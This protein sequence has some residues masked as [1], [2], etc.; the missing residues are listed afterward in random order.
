MRHCPEPRSGDLMTERLPT[1]TA[2]RT[3]PIRRAAVAA[4]ATAMSVLLIAGVAAGLNDSLTLPAPPRASLAVVCLAAAIILARRTIRIALILLLTIAASVSLASGLSAGEVQ[5]ALGAWTEIAVLLAVVPIVSALLVRRLYIQVVI[6]AATRVGALATQL[7]VLISG[8]VIGS[9][10]LLAVVPV[11]G[12]FLGLRRQQPAVRQHYAQ[13]ILRGFVSSVAWSPSTGA[14][15]VIV[16]ATGLR[17]T[18]LAPALL[19]VGGSGLLLGMLWTVAMHRRS[20]MPVELSDEG[21]IDLSTDRASDRNRVL[22]LIGFLTVTFVLI[23]VLELQDFASTVVVV[24]T[25]MLTTTLSLLFLTSGPRIAATTV[26]DHLLVRMPR[27]AGEAAFLLAAGFLG[28]VLALSGFSEVA[29]GRTLELA[30]S[31]GI[32]LQAVLPLLVVAVTLMGVPP[33]VS[34]ALISG[35]IP[36]ALTG[37]EPTLY[38]ALL[39]IG[40]GTS[41]LIAPL[42]PTMLMVANYAGT[43]PTRSGVRA[44]KWFAPIYLILLVMTANGVTAL[45]G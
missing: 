21:L 36:L 20:D 45:L 31:I 3:D 5:Q 10:A 1:D 32:S 43:D 14:M 30:G 27:G 8:H 38:A 25:V 35:A 17:W 29:V 6:A 24:P 15:G 7:A 22:E 39:V 33:L 4:Y 26:R 18:Q 28:S 16:L 34:V 42:T 44:N 9:V 12:D 41:L 23:L 37:M 40:S 19:I 13:L 11:L 2:D